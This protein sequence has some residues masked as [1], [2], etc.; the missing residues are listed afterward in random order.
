MFVNSFALL[1]ASSP[2]YEAYVNSDFLGKMIFLSLLASSVCCWT[3][4]IH[5]VLLT[6][7]VKKNSNSFQSVFGRSKSNPLNIDIDKQSAGLN[8]FYD[9]WTALKKQTIDILNKNH[10][11][12]KE[13]DAVSYLSSS[14]IDCIAS[15][16]GS[17][18]DL[19]INK[20]EKNLFILATIVGL[21]PLLGLLGTVWG[22]LTSFS[23]L[24]SQA[25]G[26]TN[27]MMLSGISLALTTTVLGILNA[28][29][30]L[31]AYNYLKS[32][33]RSFEREMEGFSSEMLL[34]VEMQYR[35]VDLQ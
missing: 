9:L 35:K 32:A 12:G 18:I 20:L 17:A 27:Q 14:D 30:A 8:P 1:S 33:T 28:I 13:T 11:F 2:F 21:A 4:L 16:L 22:I 26:A 24:E 29:P 25:Q 6:R 7:K 23:G 19:E 15:H 34:S 3:I 10:R 31:V 5:K